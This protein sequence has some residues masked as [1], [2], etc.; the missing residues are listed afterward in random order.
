MP[1]TKRIVCLAMSRKHSGRCVAGR[2][3]EGSSAGQWIRPVS[4]RPNEEVSEYERQ[5]ED[6]RDPRVLDVIEVPLLAPRPKGYQSENWLLDPE[7]YWKK[8][9]QL[10]A[11]Y[12]DDYLAPVGPLWTDGASTFHG[13]NNQISLDDAETLDSSLALVRVSGI[14][15]KVFVPG[16]KFG[17]SKRRVDASFNHAGVPYRLRITDPE[18][19]RRFLAQPNGEYELG[20]CY[21]TVSIG[22]PFKGDV[23][24]LIAAIIEAD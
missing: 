8:V 5:Y 15:L 14:D 16:A 17:D 11:K 6:G 12:L 23:Y 4:D 19:E 18:F 7:S 1:V 10:E 9:G 3:V 21:L 20:P 2:E 24:K 13:M 22:E